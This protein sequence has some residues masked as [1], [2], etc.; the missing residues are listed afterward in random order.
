MAMVRRFALILAMGVVLALP[1]TAAA[2]VR[3]VSITSPI[4]AGSYATL[5]VSVSGTDVL[6]HRLL[7]ERAAERAGPL[8]EAR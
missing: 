7:Q 6:D 1:A 3:L 5:T 8:P 2:S 4:S